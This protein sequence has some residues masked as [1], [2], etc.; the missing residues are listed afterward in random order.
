MHPIYK[1]VRPH[2]GVDYAAPKGTSVQAVGAGTVISAGWTSGGGGNTIA[3]RH[4]GGYETRYLHLSRIMVKRGA[5]V[6]QGD[7]I[8]QVG[9]TGDSTGPH[10]DFR[11]YKNGKAINP[12]TV[13]FPPGNPVAGEKMAEFTELCARL[14]AQLN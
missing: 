13:V 3:I 2:L 11:V 7:I 12:T 9:S 5:R 10:L 14:M 1:V 6:G 8:G 4:S